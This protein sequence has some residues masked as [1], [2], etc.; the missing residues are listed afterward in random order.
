VSGGRALGSTTRPLAP[1]DGLHRRGG[2]H[3]L[4]RPTA[5]LLR[6]PGRLLRLRSGPKIEIP[7]CILK[8]DLRAAP[9]PQS[10]TCQRTAGSRR[11]L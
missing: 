7:P 9:T 4:Q 3:R 10:W 2:R 1:A 11:A 5:M 6:R 8:V